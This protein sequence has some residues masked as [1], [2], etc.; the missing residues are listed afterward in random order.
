ML[1]PGL[2]EPDR[3]LKTFISREVV[4]LLCRLVPFNNKEVNGLQMTKTVCSPAPKRGKESTFE[5]TLIEDSRCA[6]EIQRQQKAS[7]RGESSC[8]CR[9]TATS[10]YLFLFGSRRIAGFCNTAA[11]HITYQGHK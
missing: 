10:V 1:Q 9:F 8:I 6:Q 2:G 11:F 5:E 7:G 3:V 4:V